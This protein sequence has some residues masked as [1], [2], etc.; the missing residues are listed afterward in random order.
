MLN[1]DLSGGSA[2]SVM[3][4][5]HMAYIANADL[6]H[7]VKFK[8]QIGES[9]EELDRIQVSCDISVNEL[10]IGHELPL[11]IRSHLIEFF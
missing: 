5:I 4:G 1:E 2:H 3:P 9:I 8:G 7:G 11:P 10:R 6:D